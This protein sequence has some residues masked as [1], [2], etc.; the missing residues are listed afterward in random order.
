MDL[1]A[2]LAFPPSQGARLSERPSR[3]HLPEG[4]PSGRQGQHGRGPQA[5]GPGPVDL[6]L[7]VGPGPGGWPVPRCRAGAFATGQGKRYRRGH[8]PRRARA[9]QTAVLRHGARELAGSLTRW[10]AAARSRKPNRRLAPRGMPLRLPLLGITTPLPPLRGHFCDGSGGGCMPAVAL[11]TA[12][13]LWWVDFV[14]SGGPGN[15][16]VQRAGWG[17]G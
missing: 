15:R 6:R 7:R 8:A 10:E 2:S 14:N 17:L 12:F 9:G 16:A 11:C 13:D 4:P 5:R 3:W 1:P